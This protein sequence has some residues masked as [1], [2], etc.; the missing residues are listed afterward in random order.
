[1]LLDV[2]AFV[3]YSTIVALRFTARRF[4]SLV[5]SNQN[6]VAKQRRIWLTV[7]ENHLALNDVEDRSYGSRVEFDSTAP[8]ILSDLLTSLRTTVGLHNLERITFEDVNWVGQ[9]TRALFD[10]VPAVRFVKTVGVSHYQPRS[11]TWASS[12]FEALLSGFQRLEEMVLR[13]VKSVEW[14]I[15]QSAG[16]LSLRSVII[17]T[18]DAHRP[19][20]E[21]LL[22]FCVDSKFRSATEEKRIYLKFQVPQK[23]VFHLIAVRI[24]FIG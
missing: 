15:L 19:S 20:V 14:D 23:F 24:V 8:R 7:A 16:V 21:E 22:R 17:I 12:D 13:I 9:P 4:S 11:Q 6:A 3:D 18:A 2:L 1:M 5:D 10:E